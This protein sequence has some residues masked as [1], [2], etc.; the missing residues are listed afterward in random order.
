M[1]R[2]YLCSSLSPML[3]NSGDINMSQERLEMFLSE[4]LQCL[5]VTIPPQITGI[6]LR[7]DLRRKNAK[8]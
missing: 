2:K 5:T 8:I 6:L 7:F 3:S 1:G 4:T